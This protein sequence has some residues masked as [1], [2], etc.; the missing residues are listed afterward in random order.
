M[1]IPVRGAG[2]G[3]AVQAMLRSPEPK[4]PVLD[5]AEIADVRGN[6]APGSQFIELLRAEVNRVNS[7]HASADRQ[8]E[9]LVVGRSSDIHGTM[10]ALTKA[11]MSFRL[12]TQVRNKALEAY[13]E[14]MRMN[15]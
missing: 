7:T 11:D 15:L 12:M 13:Q 4:G 10:I 6:A 1:S 5:K 8:V 14:I 3:P 9:D 2:L